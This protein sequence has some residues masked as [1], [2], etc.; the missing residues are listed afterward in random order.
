[1]VKATVALRCSKEHLSVEEFNKTWHDIKSVSGGT[2]DRKHCSM[3]WCLYEA[4]RELELG[5]MADAES[6]SIML[7][8][9]NGRLLAKYSAS[10][11]NLMSVWVALR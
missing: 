1:M 4:W 10:N 3:Q 8:E 6:V 11:K 2:K 7:D 9:R 5:F